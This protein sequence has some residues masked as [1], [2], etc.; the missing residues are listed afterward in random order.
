ML[1][2][3]SF[4][5]LPALLLAAAVSH[6]APPGFV[7]PP[8]TYRYPSGRDNVSPARRTTSDYFAPPQSYYLRPDLSEPAF[9]PWY[10]SYS[11]S[12]GAPATSGLDVPLLAR[13]FR[14]PLPPVPA[15]AEIEVRVPEGAELWF[16]G[17]KTRQ[18]G[19]RRMFTSP[20]LEPGT[21]YAY[22]VKARWTQDGK[23]VERT[24]HVPVTAGTRRAVDFTRQEK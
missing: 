24:L 3:R 6:A 21:S 20:P 1:R 10:R 16:N 9:P 15:P 13:G 11:T 22:D 2:T 7:S 5:L 23:A 8:S 19:A 18:T 4:A 14:K 12:H 17:A